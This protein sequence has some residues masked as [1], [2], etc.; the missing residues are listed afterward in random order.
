M[1]SYIVTGGAGFI[2]SNIVK[3]LIAQGNKVYVLDDLLTGFERNLPSDAIFYNVD[4]S[5]VQAVSTLSLPEK[6]DAVYHFAAQ[7]SGEASF[8]DPS[9]DC[10]INYKSTYHMLELAKAKGAKRFMYASSMSVYGEVP[11]SFGHIDEEYNCQPVS[12]YGSH[13][14]ASEHMIR[15]FCQKNNIDSTIF[16]LFNVYGPG[17]NMFNMKQGMVSIYMTFLLHDKPIHVKGSLDRF[18]DFIYVEDIVDGFLKSE[19]DER[20]YGEVLNLGTGEKTTVRDLLSSML[21]AYGK[22][23]FD[24]WVYVEGSTNGD[25]KGCVSNISK[26]KE[27]LEWSPKFSIEQGVMRMKEWLDDTKALWLGKEIEE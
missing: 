27:I 8:E 12:Y 6:I 20:T 14:L 7:P 24:Q 5:N 11:G 4:I 21:R 16:R 25:T 26:V 15:I 2:G 9:R 3:K 22:D 17:Q 1:K 10:D 13:K 23:D 18:R 19:D